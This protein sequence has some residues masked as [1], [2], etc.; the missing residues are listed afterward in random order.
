MLKTNDSL[1]VAG[2]G[3]DG[4]GVICG[5]RG[6]GAMSR[7]ALSDLVRRAGLP[8]SWMPA[9]KDARVQLQRAVAAVASAQNLRAARDEK[10]GRNLPW[11]SRWALWP[12]AGDLEVGA[13]VGTVA[14]VVTLADDGTL[15]FETARAELEADVRRE[16]T[17]LVEA[18]LYQAADITKWLH[19]I[20]RERLDG[21]RLGSNWYVPRAKRAIAESI[22]AAFGERWGESWITPPLPVATSEQLASGIASG[23]IAEVAE[24]LADLENQRAQRRRDMGSTA[25]IGVR[26]AEGF[27]L[28]FRHVGTRVDMYAELIGAARVDQVRDAIGEAAVQLDVVLGSEESAVAA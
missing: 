28:R 12:T 3:A 18:Q 20:H 14:L 13:S 15:T 25:D 19:E 16:Y 1:V 5:Y 17:A 8:E 10:R 26:A 24:V 27:M 4:H 7:L 2:A 9:P 22:T 11:V 6:E 21:V 23:L